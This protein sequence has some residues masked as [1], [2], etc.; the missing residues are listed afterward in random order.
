MIDVYMEQ[1]VGRE[2]A[3]KTELHAENGPQRQTRDFSVHVDE[4]FL[5]CD[6]IQT[7]S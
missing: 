6:E 7:M 2:A 1:L 4:W 5:L 3:G